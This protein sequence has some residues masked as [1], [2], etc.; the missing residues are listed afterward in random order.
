MPMSAKHQRFKHLICVCYLND[1]YF[2]THPKNML[3]GSNYTDGSQHYFFYMELEL[4][5]STIYTLLTRSWKE[6]HSN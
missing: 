6:H 5:Q 3:K 1:R 4:S 2:C